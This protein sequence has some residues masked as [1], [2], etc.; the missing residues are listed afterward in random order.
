[1]SPC[2]E[3]QWEMTMTLSIT[4]RGTGLM[5]SGIMTAFAIFPFAIDLSYPAALAKVTAMGLTGPALIF[6]AKFAIAWPVLFHLFNGLR[7]LVSLFTHPRCWLIYLF[8]P[9]ILFIIHKMLKY[10][11]NSIYCRAGIWATDSKLSTSTKQDG[12]C[13]HFQL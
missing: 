3:W 7:H 1:M 11:C 4:H 6:A 10:F 8:T 5:Q 13:Q 12:R 9:W 2:S